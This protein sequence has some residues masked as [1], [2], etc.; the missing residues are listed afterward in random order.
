MQKLKESRHYLIDVEKC[1][2]NAGGRYELII[3]GAKRLREM[4]KQVRNANQIL[5]T[6][7][8]LLEYQN[9]NAK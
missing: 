2:K 5:T 8:V 6:I 7:D 4:R 1:A 3:N 9:L